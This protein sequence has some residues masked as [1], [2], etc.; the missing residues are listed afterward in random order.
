MFSITLGGIP[1][2]FSKNE[3]FV[4]V[5]GKMN[6][7]GIRVDKKESTGDYTLT[8]ISESITPWESD[9]VSHDAT[10]KEYVIVNSEPGGLK[11]AIVAAGKDYTQLKNLKIT[12]QIDS[13]D[14][15]FMRDSM[16]MLRALNLKEVRI[17]SGF[18]NNTKRLSKFY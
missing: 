15:Y 8:L 7:F 18:Y 16:N 2:K 17:K 13:R 6:N 4:Y 5:S 12:G 3:E 10:S 1:Y 14:F 9:L 11:N